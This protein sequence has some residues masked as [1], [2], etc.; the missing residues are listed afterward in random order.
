MDV[1]CQ[2]VPK[3][4]NAAARCWPLT[5]ALVIDSTTGNI[6]HI[7]R[8]SGVAS[9]HNIAAFRRFG[10]RDGLLSISFGLPSLN[11]EFFVPFHAVFDPIT[12]FNET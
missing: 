5:G 7:A 3:A 2:E 9:S 11:P 6:I 12:I 8:S 1:R 10:E 4:W